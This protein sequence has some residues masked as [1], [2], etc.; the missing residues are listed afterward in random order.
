MG[1]KK[2]EKENKGKGIE[3][4]L[5]GHLLKEIPI[6]KIIVLLIQMILWNNFEN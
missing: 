3:H 5:L 6:S 1:T 4:Y 2:K